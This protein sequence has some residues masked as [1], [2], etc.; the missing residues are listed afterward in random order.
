M[1]T[2]AR[3]KYA[4]SLRLALQRRALFLTSLAIVVAVLAGSGTRAEI[5][6]INGSGSTFAYPIYSKWI[7]EYRK[8]VPDVQFAY[9]PTGSGAGIHDVMLG[10]A[11]FG[12]TDGPLSKTQML[13]F[14][15]HRNCDVL[16]LPT[17]LGADVP[18]Y[19]IPGVIQELN[20]TPAALA[21]IYLGTITK[22]NDPQIAKA[23]PDVPLPSHDIAVIHRQ[24]GSGTTYV[25]TDYLSKVSPEWKERVGTGISV[26]WPV[27]YGA[28]GNQGLVRHVAETPYSIGYAE[29]TYAVR[30]KVFY[31]SVQNQAGQFVK[32][33]FA[34]VTAAAASIGGKMPRDFRV[35]ITDA[36]GTG[37]YPIS[38]FT[39]LLIPSVI[40]DPVK[41]DAIVD[42]VRWGLTKGQGYL[43]PLSYARLPPEV[44]AKEEKAIDYL[45]AQGK[46]ITIL[47]TGGSFPAPLYGRWFSDYNQL[48]PE[49]QINFQSI[50]SGSGAGIKQFQRGLVDFAASDAAMT[51]EQIAVVKSGVVLLP[52]T[53]GCVVIAYDLP[54]GPQELKLSREAYTGIF[55]GKVTHWDDPL[56]AKS[57]PGEKLPGTRVTV[58]TKSDASG[59]TFVFTTHLS[60]ISEAWKNGPGVGMSVSFPVGVAGKGTMGV[61][62]LIKQTPGAIGYIEYGYATHAGLP[63]ALLENR[64]GKFIRP[65]VATGLNALAD[66]KL[67]ANLRGWLPDPPGE[68]AYPIVSYTWLLVRKKYADPRMAQVLKS[69]ISFGLNHGQGYSGDLGYLPLPDDVIKAVTIAMGQIS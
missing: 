32:A 23:N 31:G 54:G 61:A 5:L 62:A 50:G 35:S 19:Y 27:G 58:I 2:A 48:H 38:S 36:A 46:P 45:Q 30:E 34:T 8:V 9:Q 55:L 26:N 39:W 57:N 16:H 49:V 60:A 37:A 7:D 12:G 65:D 20:F 44:I 33:D 22:W 64:A 67:P 13:D 52:L 10:T 6:Q 66:L 53:A 51:D 1:T 28:K 69:V 15:S 29:L 68:D 47:G 4:M 40:P 25:W 59:T 63:V 24:D 17:A 42:F 43:Q 14:N 3:E 18:V 21:G 41:R 11:D 56:I